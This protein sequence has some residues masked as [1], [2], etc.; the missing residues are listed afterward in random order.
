MATWI[1]EERAKTDN[2]K[3][4]REYGRGSRQAVGCSLPPFLVLRS[5]IPCTAERA[6]WIERLTMELLVQSYIS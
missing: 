1:A 2:R 5:L 6:G 3:M 4:N